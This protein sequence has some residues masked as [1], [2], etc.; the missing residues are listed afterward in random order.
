MQVTIRHWSCDEGNLSFD[1][2]SKKI[3]SLLCIPAH[4]NLPWITRYRCCFTKKNSISVRSQRLLLTQSYLT[5]RII[6][7][8]LPLRYEKNW[9]PYWRQEAEQL[10]LSD[11]IR[12]PV[13]TLR[14][15]LNKLYKFLNVKLIKSL[16]QEQKLR[17]WHRGYRNMKLLT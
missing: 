10:R 6:Y 8:H 14:L 2:K 9:T 1:L 3:S 12:S 5:N 7:V 13:C 15:Y 17:V 16:K 4:L 11:R